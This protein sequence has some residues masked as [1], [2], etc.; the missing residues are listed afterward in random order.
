M[1]TRF[2]H[3]ALATAALG[4]ALSPLLAATTT[5][6]P[7]WSNTA[8]ALLLDPP[9]APSHCRA[10]TSYDSP[11]DT[12]RVVVTWDDNSTNEDGFTLE[13]WSRQSGAWVLVRSVGEAAN[14]TRGVFGFIRRPTQIK[15]RVQAFNTSGDSS[16]S[17]WAR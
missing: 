9:A 13:E 2:M 3:K 12:W 11:T 6:S 1:A 10:T 7:A 4:I 16:W 5:T 14:S 17:N 8:G 15:F